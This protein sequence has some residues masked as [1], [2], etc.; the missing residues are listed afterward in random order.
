MK[1]FSGTIDRV[2]IDRAARLLTD[3]IDTLDKRV[4]EGDETAWAAY[5]E[6]LRTLTALLPHLGPDRGA[7]L[8][9]AQM[10]ERFGIRPKTLL[11]H[12]AKGK[13]RPAIVEG[14]L[15]RWRGN[16]PL[17]GSTDGN[18]TRK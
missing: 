15:L 7:L 10:A 3:R 13:I 4:R 16:E 6:T 11:K 14:K 1:P 12:K 18:A 5:Q 9:R 17:D 8:T 2:R